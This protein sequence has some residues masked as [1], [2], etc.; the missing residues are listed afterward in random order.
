MSTRDTQTHLQDDRIT[1]AP[2]NPKIL[3]SPEVNKPLG[4][5]I[6]KGPPSLKFTRKIIPPPIKIHMQ[7]TVYMMS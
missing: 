6:A 7:I 4:C 5:S 3:Q 1:Y 2:E